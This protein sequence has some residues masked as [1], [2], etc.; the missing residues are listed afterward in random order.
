M[1]TLGRFDGRHGEILVLE[2]I[3]TGYRRYY[4]G[5]AFQSEVAPGGES[6]FVYVHIMARLLCKKRRV[7]LLGCGGGSLATMLRR[8]GADV[9]VVDHDP[10][11]FEVARRWFWMPPSV[12]CV[13]ADFR[14]F[15]ARDE[16]MWDGIGVDVGD[17]TFDFLAAF[18]T[19]TCGRLRRA[20]VPDGVVVANTMVEHDLDA[21][22]DV[23]AARLGGDPRSA[24][25]W[26]QTGES[27]R[28]AILAVAAA[29]AARPPR[30]DLGDGAV[31]EDLRDE[32]AG[33]TARP[34]RRRR[35]S[36]TTSV[37]SLR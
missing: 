37:V 9:T 13:V 24:R 8:E 12:D 31:P 6:R 32:L 28:N 3:A 35:V 23:V 30:L 26:E 21:T 17:A 5:T 22:A 15:L 29:R 10:M 18:D 25:I 36:D 34:P 7:L 1:R 16:R 27:E 4:E 11:S 2:E 20:L 14:D 19:A 33:W